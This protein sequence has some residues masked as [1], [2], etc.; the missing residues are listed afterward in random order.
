MKEKEDLYDE[1][2]DIDSEKPLNINDLTEPLVEENNNKNSKKKINVF[3]S[4][5]LNNNNYEPP[6]QANKFLHNSI[7][8]NNLNNNSNNPINR[9]RKEI[10]ELNKDNETEISNY[11]NNP[12]TQ[13]I[14]IQNFVYIIIIT[15][16]S[17]LQFGI[18][19]FIF[20]LYMNSMN[21]PTN[22]ILG[23]SLNNINNLN[24]PK[25]SNKGL[26]Y[27]FFLVLSW[28]YQIY[29]FIYLAYATYIYFKFKNNIKKI[30]DKNNNENINE[31]SSPLLNRSNSL[32]SQN[33]F[34]NSFPG[35]PTFKFR[36]FK[37]KYLQKCGYG[38]DSYINIFLLTSNIFDIQDNNKN[39]FNYFFNINELIKGLTG[40]FFSYL[41]FAGSYFY[42]FGII[43]LIQE[44]TALL[45]YYIQYNKKININNNNNNGN[46]LK[47]LSNKLFKQSNNGE[48]Y[49]YIFP[50]LMS[51]GFYYLQKTI[52]NNSLFLFILL[53]FCIGLQIFNQKK[54][55]LDSH[56]ESPFQIL[57]RTYFNY[58]I[59]S[60]I[61]VFVVEIFLNGFHIRNLFYWLTDIKIFL[62]CLFGF[63]I[64]G[65]ICYNMLILFMRISLSNNII[66]KLIKYFN[67]II[68]DI[69]GIYIFRQYTI[70][71]YLDYIVGLSLCAVSMFL[72]DFHK[73]L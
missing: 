50:L 16:F 26:L 5:N 57:F 22:N 35:N 2:I 58:T 18:Y 4:V 71:S 7:N 12:G 49:K 34:V 3:K 33:S 10:N 46:K 42:Y 19:I 21:M 60:S 62:A 28:K 59:I 63:G 73:I 31:D 38:Y 68:I 29:L 43:Y 17:S 67:L 66:I 24:I 13:T 51:F 36:E 25:I 54:F 72:L 20:N 30:E 69:I 41:I 39:F 44:I 64:C 53:I 40:I 47:N 48:Y 1:K 15:I 8:A 70:V 9:I 23:N 55:V 32:T 45:P 37:Y 65:A 6:I 61:F 11:S 27:A 14:K 52:I 56:E